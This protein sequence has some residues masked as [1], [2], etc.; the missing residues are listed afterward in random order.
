MSIISK[1]RAFVRS[2]S[3][4]KWLVIF[5]MLLLLTSSAFAGSVMAGGKG[6]RP[7]I[8]VTVTGQTLHPI[9]IMVEKLS[10]EDGA[11]TTDRS[12]R[13][14]GIL[15]AESRLMI[16]HG[17]EKA[18]ETAREVLDKLGTDPSADITI[19]YDINQT[20]G[21]TNITIQVGNKT[22]SLIFPTPAWSDS[23]AHM[24]IATQ[25]W[26]TAMNMY[27]NKG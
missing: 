25:V 10:Y 21:I 11:R 23:A 12:E 2:N 5:L 3:K 19:N 6:K 8:K 7:T 26:A 18:R 22:Q 14:I 17:S 4:T 20:S 24:A 27:S 13:V 16:A 15:R 1:S 9:A